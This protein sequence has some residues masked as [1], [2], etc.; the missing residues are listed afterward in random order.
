MKLVQRR[1]QSG[2]HGLERPQ[3]HLLVGAEKSGTTTVAAI[4]SQHSQISLSNPKEP[5]YFTYNFHRGAAWYDTHFLRGSLLRV[6]A[7]TSY[8]A[9]PLTQD[10]D[11]YR[12]SVPGRVQTT[13]P[14][15][16]FIYL[17]RDPVDRC[18]SAYW[19]NVRKGSEHRRFRQAVQEFSGYV[20]PSLYYYQ[21]SLYLEKFPLSRF[22]IVRFEDFVVSPLRTAHALAQ[23]LNPDFAEFAFRLEG[24][25]NGSYA[26]NRL[27]RK[28]TSLTRERDRAWAARALKALA[29][30]PVH[31]AVLR[32]LTSQIPPMSADDRDFVSGLLA[33]DTRQFTRLT[34]ISWPVR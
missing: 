33:Q 31:A 4:L 34:G 5:D 13:L 9:A 19:H 29:P 14:D 26:P 17:V 12:Y 21:I 3:T 6:D 20:E 22:R 18:Y 32:L 28:L 23:F 2:A 7:S 30:R 16:R 25:R 27:G 15:A 1:G 11:D 24:T 8:T 10:R